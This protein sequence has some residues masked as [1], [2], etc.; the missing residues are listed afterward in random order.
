MTIELLDIEYVIREDKE[1]EN[2]CILSGQSKSKNCSA[3]L[4]CSDEWIKEKGLFGIFEALK[5]LKENLIFQK[6]NDLL[7]KE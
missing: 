2:S 6:T 4:R 7:Y 3:H 5:G 1:K